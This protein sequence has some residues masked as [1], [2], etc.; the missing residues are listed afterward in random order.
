MQNQSGA[1]FLVENLGN[2]SVVFLTI[3]KH[4]Q[5]SINVASELLFPKIDTRF[6]FRYIHLFEQSYL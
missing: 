5:Q 1:T 4:Q 6:F 3:S 2:C